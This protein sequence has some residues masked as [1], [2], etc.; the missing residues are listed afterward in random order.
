MGEGRLMVSKRHRGAALLRELVAGA[1]AGGFGDGLV[2]TPVADLAA[3]LDALERW[4]AKEIDR[5]LCCTRNE[6]RADAAERELAAV[7]EAIGEAWFADGITLVQAVARK[8]RAL[9]H[10]AL[11]GHVSPRAKDADDDL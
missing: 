5:A 7:R 2:E 8:T 9:E 10:L 4:E 6:A 3:V 11:A 1:R